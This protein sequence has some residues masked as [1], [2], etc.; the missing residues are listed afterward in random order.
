MFVETFQMNQTLRPTGNYSA[1]VCSTVCT[2]NDTPGFGP[3]R[4]VDLLIQKGSFSLSVID[5]N[6]H[7]L[8]HCVCELITGDD[9]LL[10]AIFEP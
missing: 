5:L 7:L 4:H 10:S 9:K 8:H 2:L 3:E 1:A 6:P